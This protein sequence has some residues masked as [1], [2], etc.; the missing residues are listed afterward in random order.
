MYRGS[1][2]KT[3]FW[4]AISKTFRLK[5]TRDIT[6]ALNDEVGKKDP[7]VFMEVYSYQTHWH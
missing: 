4:H 2:F 6:E 7:K 5:L 3:C 1:Y